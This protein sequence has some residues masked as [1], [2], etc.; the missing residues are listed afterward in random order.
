MKS[1]AK[2]LISLT[3]ILFATQFAK[4]EPYGQSTIV[5]DASNYAEQKLVLSKEDAKDLAAFK[6]ECDALKE[7]L[8]DY[9]QALIDCTKSGGPPVAW[10][11][12]P[13]FVVGGIGVSFGVG[14]IVGVIVAN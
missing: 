11:Q 9:K 8:S 7:D 6:L 2:T 3:A 1:T 10:W 4:A 13:V 12:D 14:L 5:L